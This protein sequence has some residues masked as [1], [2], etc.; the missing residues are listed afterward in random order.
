MAW[1]IAAFSACRGHETEDVPFDP[2]ALRS[3]PVRQQLACC[4][5]ALGLDVIC[6]QTTESGDADADGS[7]LLERV[8]LYWLIAVG[9]WLDAFMR[10]AWLM[11]L[12]GLFRLLLFATP[13]KGGDVNWDGPIRC[14]EFRLLASLLP[15]FVLLMQWILGS[16][17][18]LPY[19]IAI[20]N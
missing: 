2:R 14:E 17:I 7:C 8:L 4:S 10:A 9:Q 11:S 15:I 1:P 13:L 6:S 16:G 12:L 19:W 20:F 5:S 3:E 18:V